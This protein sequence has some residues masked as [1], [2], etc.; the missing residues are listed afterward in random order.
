MDPTAWWRANQPISTPCAPGA[1]PMS[2]PVS[3]NLTNTACPKAPCPAWIVTIP[4]VAPCPARCRP[5]KPTNR[6]APNATANWFFGIQRELH[7]KLTVELNYVGT[8]GRNLFRAE[9]VNRV[10]GAR[11]PEGTCV[12]DN[13]GRRL[14]SQR[15]SNT[16]PNG[17]PINPSGQFLNP[18]FGRLRVWENTSSSSY[19]SMQLSVRKQASHGLQFRG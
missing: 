8:L 3:R 1:T 17:L 16:A 19:N 9:N 18:N 5:P 7:P 2:G 11:L 4:T 15:N 10:P 12:T 13:F 6:G 14:C